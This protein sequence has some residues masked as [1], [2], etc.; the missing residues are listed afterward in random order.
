MALSWQ[1]WLPSSDVLLLDWELLQF[2]SQAPTLQIFN[3]L[4]NVKS[5]A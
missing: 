3:I 2:S 1:A 4:W 5:D